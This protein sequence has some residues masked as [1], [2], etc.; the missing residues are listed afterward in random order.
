MQI[1]DF[2][3]AV[4][5]SI[6]EIASGSIGAAAKKIESA[7]AQAIP[8]LIG[9]LASL[10]GLGGISEKIKEFI[11]KVQTKVDAAID[12][13]IAKVIGV[14]KKLVG[15]VKA[16][17]KALLSW[18]KRETKFAAGGESHR[19]F[20]TGS[21]KSAALRVAS[22]ELSLRDFLAQAR[23]DGKD[24]KTI[25]QIE[26]LQTNI[27]SL[28]AK[29][30]PPTP[31]AEAP[32]DV[33]INAD[34]D[35]IALLLPTLFSGSEWGTE[36]N[37]M[38]IME[39]PKKSASLYRTI[40]LGPRVNGALKQEHLKEAFG[41]TP[42]PTK[43]DSDLSAP[44]EPTKKAL[45]TWVD[46]GGKVREYRP[47]QKGKW[48]D[49]GAYGGV[50]DLGVEERFLAQAGT[51]F[52]YLRGQTPGGR[53]LNAALKKFGYY[54][55]EAGEN[56]DGDHILEAQLIGTAPTSSATCGRW[57]RGKTG[58]A[59]TSTRRRRSKSPVRSFRFRTWKRQSAPRTR[60]RRRRSTS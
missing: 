16:A 34:F 35:S 46:N 45:K 48:P 20:F 39:Y 6:Y 54:G 8:L 44:I 57:T 13:A 24:K 18:W 21:A 4:V 3:E 17:A 37:P 58:T 36:T 14:V 9:F 40:Y 51:L 22:D 33:L 27:E 41:K 55:R 43:P 19:L 32:E 2:V 31:D 26:G 11:F 42:G 5:G 30:K 59:R 50:A 25:D 53:K 28:R 15:G 7:L 60:R 49:G 29:R 47:F 23:K 56:S 12:K 10:L 1:L 52:K 38:L